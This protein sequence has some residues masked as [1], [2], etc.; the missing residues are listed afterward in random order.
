MSRRVRLPEADDLFRPTAEAPEGAEQKA[1]SKRPKEDAASSSTGSAKSATGS[2][3]PSSAS[4][5]IKHDEKITV[6][7][8]AEELMA[9][10]QARLVLRAAHGVSADRGRLVRTAI[11][12]ALADLEENGADSHLV[13]RLTES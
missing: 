5:R 12:L 9:V 11:A 1:S 13:R 8:T 10:E 7:V 3:S 4:G 2:T 6:Y